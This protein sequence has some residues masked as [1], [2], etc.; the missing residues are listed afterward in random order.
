VVGLYVVTGGPTGPMTADISGVSLRTLAWILLIGFGLLSLL[1]A[2]PWLREHTVGASVIASV[3]VV[4]GMWLERWNIIVPT[5]T[6]ARLVPWSIYTPSLTEVALTAG[7]F[8]IFGLLFLGFFRIFPAISI[9]E[10]SEGR[11][12]EKAASQVVIPTPEPTE[13]RPPRRWGIRPR[14]ITSRR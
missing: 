1:T 9:W 5:M 13:T 12:L 14:T 11:V 2:S 3:C 10:I 8:A 4:I 7:S 6:H